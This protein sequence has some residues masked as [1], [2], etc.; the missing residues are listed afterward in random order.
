MRSDLQAAIFGL[1]IIAAAGPFVASHATAQ[2][3][4]T[5]RLVGRVIRGPGSPVSGLPGSV[6]WAA[7][8]GVKLAVT[9]IAKGATATVTTDATG[10]YRVNL[11]AATYEVTLVTIANS[12]FTKDLP[13]TVTIEPGRETRLDVRID[14]GI[15]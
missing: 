2:Q 6:D 5:G 1:V 15:R 8:A 7:A 4:G 13:A 14:T 9:D 3:A 10:H 11:G 12:E